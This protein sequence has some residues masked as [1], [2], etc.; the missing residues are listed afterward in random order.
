MPEQKGRKRTPSRRNRASRAQ[1]AAPQDADVSDD[2]PRAERPARQPRFSTASAGSGLP[3]APL[4]GRGTR[5][6]GV[7]IGIITA[8]FAVG[9][10]YSAIITASGIDLVLRVAGGLILLALAIALAALSLIPGA[11]RDRFRPND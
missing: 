5:V 1:R 7:V 6:A 10:F 11:I 9:L 4:P 2:A 8:A 3:T